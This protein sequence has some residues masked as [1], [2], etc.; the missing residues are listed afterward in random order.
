[1]SELQII[2]KNEALSLGLKKYFTGRPC[3]NGHVSERFCNSGRCLDCSVVNQRAWR[4]SNPEKSRESSRKWKK[5]NPEKFL[6][7]SMAWRSKNPEKCRESVRKWMDVNPD[8]LRKNSALRRAALNGAKPKWLSKEHLAEISSIYR[9][10]VDLELK[11]GVKHHV[12]HIVPLQGKN[13]SGLHVPWN[14]QVIP[15]V[16]NMKKGNRFNDR[17]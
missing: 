2:S 1:M 16:E 3:R 9:S 14:L 10:A 17:T 15:A 13:V 7:S 6:K 4:D 12:D 5:E 11:T 8:K